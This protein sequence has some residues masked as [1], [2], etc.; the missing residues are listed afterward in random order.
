MSID[1]IAVAGAGMTAFT[2]SSRS[3]RAASQEAVVSA[4]SP[5]GQDGARLLK[6]QMCSPVGDVATLVA[7][8]SSSV[9]RCLG[10]ARPARP[11]LLNSTDL[12]YGS[13]EKAAPTVVQRASVWLRGLFA[14]ADVAVVKAYEGPARA[15]SS[16]PGQLG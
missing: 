14:R 13:D 16:A 9:V 7:L 5:S 11:D 15:N 1:P 8:S 12:L 6:A 3:M 2:R 10:R 4:L